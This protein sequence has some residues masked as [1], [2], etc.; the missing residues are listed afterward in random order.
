M[1][2]PLPWV[3]WRSKSTL[4]TFRTTV[5]CMVAASVVLLATPAVSALAEC[6]ATESCGGRMIARSVSTVSNSLSS[7]ASAASSA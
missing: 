5:L 6:Q 7:A 4:S 3:R 2:P 1:A